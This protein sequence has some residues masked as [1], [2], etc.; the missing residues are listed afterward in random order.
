M[1]NI[2]FFTIMAC[3][4]GIANVDAAVR[5]TDS[6]NREQTTNSSDTNTVI[7][8]TSTRSSSTIQTPQQTA[9]KSNIISRTDSNNIVNRSSLS[10]KTVQN[11]T[12]K[13]TSTRSAT[14]ARNAVNSKSVTSSP[15]S[16]TTTNTVVR[17]SNVPARAAT[18]TSSARATS[19]SSSTATNTFGAGYNACRNAY[20]TCMDQFC[21]TANDTYR[22]CICSSRLTDV[23]ERE[24]ALSQTSGQLQDFKNLNIEV[25]PKTAEEVNAM[26]S[27]SEGEL[28]MIEDMSA[29][30]QQLAGIKEVL[31]SSKNQ[32]LS[33]LGTL[34][35]AGDIN[36]IWA[37]TDLASGQNIANLTGEALY[38]AVHSQCVNLVSEQCPSSS[39][40]NMVTSAYGMYIENDCSTLLNA[41][42]GQL[43][44]ANSTIRE[45]E[46][47]MNV[48]RLENYNAHNSKSINECIAQVRTDI[49]AETACGPDYVHC[50]DITGL[51]LNRDT[52]EP[53]YSA[54]FYQLGNQISLDGDVLTNATNRLIVAELNNKKIFAERGLETC[55]DIADE[56][57]EEF[58]RQAIVEIYQGQQEKIRNVKNECLDVVNACYDEKS[59]SLK[60]FSNVKEELLLG[61]RLE[62]SEELCKEKLYACSNLYGDPNSNGLELLLTAMHDITDQKIAAEC[63]DLLVAFAADMCTVPSNDSIHSYPY[64][65]RVYAPGDAIYASNYYCNQ[66]QWD[67]STS[68]TTNPVVPPISETGYSCPT[69]KKYT[70]CNFGYY[71]AIKNSENKWVYSGTPTLG[72]RCLTCPSDSLCPGGTSAPQGGEIGEKVDTDCGEDYVGSLYQKMVKYATQVCVRPSDYDDITTGKKTIPTNVLEDVNIVMDSVKV[73]MAKALSAECDRLGGTWVD[74]QWVNEK[75]NDPNDED[76]EDDLH[77]KTGHK[78]F[79]Y[80]YD[81]TGANTKWG[82]CADMTVEEAEEEEEDTTT[83]PPT[84]DTG[85]DTDTGTNTD[86]GT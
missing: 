47:E 73:S 10:A 27:A 5:G 21:A 68:G 23:Q 45:T 43:V 33:T 8:R 2:L 50:L 12:K 55:R 62:L 78:L 84:T 86:T 28:A 83:E 64:A 53:I 72:N 25:I 80:F 49:T 56:V 44:K 71:M 58:V 36:Q 81:E 3:C 19:L 48:T 18:N 30:S 32:A 7:A 11:N 85:T 39:T 41:L 38:N 70:S 76:G 63:H 69:Q 35:I 59:E 57:W 61:S 77:D 51:Y 16:A 74:T 46:R 6:V 20:F 24:R 75:A 40:L 1:R 29:S 22:R 26:L 31:S 13:D 4:I 67:N 17:S 14:L 37:T 66:S 9:T 60:D 42:D 82:Y 15:R 65:C 52:G 79:K 34:D 54:E